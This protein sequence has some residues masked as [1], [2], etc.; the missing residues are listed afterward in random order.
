MRVLYW[1]FGAVN[2]FLNSVARVEKLQNRQPCQ[3]GTIKNSI[4]LEGSNNCYIVVGI[5]KM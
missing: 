2:Q 1:A 3:I 4:I 5:N